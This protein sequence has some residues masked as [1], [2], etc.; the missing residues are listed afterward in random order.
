MRNHTK[1]KLKLLI[2]GFICGFSILIYSNLIH[3]QKNFLLQENDVKSINSESP[4]LANSNSLEYEWYRTWGGIEG[5]NSEEI[6]IDSV[7]SIYLGGNTYSFGSGSRDICLIKY[8][9][10][11]TKL[12]N[13]TWGGSSGDQCRGIAIDSLDNIYVAGNTGN[14]GE[15]G[16]DVFLLKYNNL[17]DLQ[18]N[19][20]WGGSYY[21]SCGAI[22]I[23]SVD[24]IYLT[25]PTYSFGAFPNSKTE[26]YLL[27]YNSLGN[28]QWNR[29]WGGDESETSKGMGIDSSGNIYLAGETN[30][31]G[32]GNDDF[33][34]VKYDNIGVFQWYRTWGG[35]TSEYLTAI[36][37]DSSDNIYITGFTHSFENGAFALVKY[38]NSGTRLWNQTWWSPTYNTTTIGLGRPSLV[39]DSSNNIY[40]SGEIGIMYDLMNTLSDVFLVKY[41]SLGTELWN[42][43][44]DRDDL[45][46]FGAIEIDSVDTVFIGGHAQNKTDY[47]L[48]IFLQG[49]DSSGSLTSNQAWGGNNDDRCGGIAIDTSDNI[50]LTGATESYGK[51]DQDICLVKWRSTNS[52]E[53]SDSKGP[54]IPGYNLFFLVGFLSIV[55]I[56][57]IKKVR[58]SSKIN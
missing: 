33:F 37:I 17:G 7:G 9:S 15:Y 57:I 20:T 2:L 4:I 18:W 44:L 23:D 43:I 53:P 52:H 5:E 1:K 28:L 47:I 26:L 21:D 32:S 56:L 14:F 30:S 51:G 36:D 45:D 50:Y 12:W 31:Y 40:L 6:V 25:G 42:R 10:L 13:Q 48:N 11:G 24:N 55:T 16:N 58:K 3:Y 27:K 41:N 49:Y 39:I 46:E 34:L 35:S 22:I 29:T 19:R 38:A 8:D 54:T